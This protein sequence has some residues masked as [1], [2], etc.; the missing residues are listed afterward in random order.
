MSN[1]S[2][3]GPPALDCGPHTPPGALAPCVIWVF[4]R[5]GRAT[6]AAPTRRPAAVGFL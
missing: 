1:P 6:L 4:P 3:S 2:G 5:R